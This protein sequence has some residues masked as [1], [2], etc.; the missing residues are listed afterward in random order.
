M[1][2]RTRNRRPDKRLLPPIVVTAAFSGILDAW[3]A[4]HGKRRPPRGNSPAA[5][6]VERWAQEVHAAVALAPGPARVL[7]IGA[8]V[9][10]QHAGPLG[11][12]VVNTRNFGELLDTYLLLEK[13]FYGRNWARLSASHGPAGQQISIAWDRSVMAPDRLLE[14]LHAMALLTL[15]RRACPALPPPLRVELTNAAQG[16]KAACRAAFGG[17]VHFGRPALRLTFPGEARQARVE[18]SDPALRPAWRNRQRTLR[19]SLPGATQFVREVQDAIMREL[20]DG[21]PADNVAARL[22]LSLRTLQRR[23]NDS[24]CSYRQLLDGVRE[25]H[26]HRLLSDPYL[27]LSGTSAA[28]RSTTCSTARSAR[29][30]APPTC[31]FPKA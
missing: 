26:A 14:Q 17:P 18:L 28:V 25:R 24:G 21:A 5:I 8:H 15:V 11:Y 22:N 19:E 20:P 1:L 30:W 16:D 7:E 13:W 27:S 6:S 2:A 23:L 4:S 29:C 31:C 3:L 10:L 12:R 9:Q